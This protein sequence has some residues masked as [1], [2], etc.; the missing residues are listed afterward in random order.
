[1]II[2]CQEI[3][4]VYAELITAFADC[5]K[6]KNEDLRKL[7]ELVMTVSTCANGGASYNTLE[8]F[9]YT[10][11]EGN[12]EITYDVNTFHAISIVVVAGF[13]IKD[14]VT[15]PAGSSYNLE[16]TALNAQDFTFTVTNGSNVLV[17]LIK[18]D[19]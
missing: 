1:M 2:E 13:I 16:F 17:E 8:T 9:N 3:N 18:E 7:T 15:I 14:N 19:I 5:N 6:I 4:Q 12:E 10:P 11:E